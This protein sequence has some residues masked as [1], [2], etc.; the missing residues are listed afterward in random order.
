MFTIFLKDKNTSAA[1]KEELNDILVKLDGF[2][3]KDMER[4]IRKFNFKSPLGNDVSEPCQFNLMFPTQ[5]GPTGD[6]KAYLRPETAQGIFINFKRL[7]EFNQVCF[8]QFLMF[9]YILI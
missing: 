6:Y 3:N 1:T 8:Y 2:D 7:Y 5:I 4:V 9:M